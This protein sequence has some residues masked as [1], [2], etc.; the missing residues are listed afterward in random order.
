ME[1]PKDLNS[2]LLWWLHLSKCD[3]FAHSSW[4]AYRYVLFALTSLHQ[5]V[6]LSFVVS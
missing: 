4:N 5:S 2:S 6:S 3:Q 1:E